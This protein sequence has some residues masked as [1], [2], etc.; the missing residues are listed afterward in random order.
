MA[1]IQQPVS[2]ADGPRDHHPPVAVHLYGLAHG[3]IWARV[4][5]GVNGCAG[6]A[7]QDVETIPRPPDTQA[8][9]DVEAGSG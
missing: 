1:V 5:G 6:Y 9:R 8:S 2:L 7:G 4:D 3:V